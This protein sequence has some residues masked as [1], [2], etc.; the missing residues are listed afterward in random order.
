[1]MSAKAMSEKIRMRRKALKDEGVEN[2]VN[3]AA[4]PQMNPQDVHN[5]KQKAVMEEAMDVPEKSMAPEDPADEDIKGTS[6]DKEHLKM[7][8]ARVKAVFDKLG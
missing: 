2:M 5:M 4:L 1:M 8:M 7:R 3:T 6:Q